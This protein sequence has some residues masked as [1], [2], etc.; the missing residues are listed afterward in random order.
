VQI[1]SPRPCD[2]SGHRE[3]VNLRFM[4]QWVVASGA[5]SRLCPPD[6]GTPQEQREVRDWTANGVPWT[7]STKPALA[8]FLRRS[9]RMGQGREVFVV[10]QGEVL[11]IG[12][13]LERAR[14][15][16]AAVP[17]AG[18]GVRHTAADN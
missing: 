6:A 8:T 13:L 18:V 11:P 12:A 2:V 9:G 5:P 14:T 15:T 4:E 17:G 10:F 7:A 1:L 16:P 3:R